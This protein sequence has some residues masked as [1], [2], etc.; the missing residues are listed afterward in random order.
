MSDSGDSSHPHSAHQTAMA[1]P[2][3]DHVPEARFQRND[4]V[5]GSHHAGDSVGGS[6]SQQKTDDAGA[7]RV[8]GNEQGL[9]RRLNAMLGT[10]SPA[11]WDDPLMLTPRRSMLEHAANDAAEALIEML[12]RL[13]DERARD[14]HLTEGG[15]VT[16][17]TSAMLTLHRALV[18][19]QLCTLRRDGETVSYE[20]IT[21]VHGA[22]VT[23]LVMRALAELRCL[24]VHEM[25]T[26]P[27]V[28]S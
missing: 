22:G 27:S 13:K 9:T 17:C 28:S 18:S 3:G 25:Q 5:A 4:T 20:T 1:D 26:L 11:D 14:V 16:S 21:R 23:T 6:S 15:S 24:I 10:P 7:A 2:V 19:Y 12:V 8:R